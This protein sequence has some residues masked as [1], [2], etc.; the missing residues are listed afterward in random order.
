MASAPAA[1]RMVMRAASR[2]ASV[3]DMLSLPGV[4]LFQRF[5]RRQALEVELLEL[6]D[7]RV[8]QRQAELRT[9]VR[10]FERPLAFHLRADLT[11]THH[12]LA[13]KPGQLADLNPIPPLRA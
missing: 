9:C 11:R 5:A 1:D 12:H 4:E 3:R 13:W 10:P 7:H 2:P 6:G 8:I